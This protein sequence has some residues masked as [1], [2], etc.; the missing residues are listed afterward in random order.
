M[1]RQRSGSTF[2]RGKGKKITWWARLTFIDEVTGKRKDLQ[3]RAESKAHA[4]ELRDELVKEY[5][6]G[7]Q[8]ALESE[9]MT[10]ADLCDYYKA[11][12]ERLPGCAHWRRR[13]RF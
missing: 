4:E 6:N 2:K 12:G 7:G 9:R 10:F 5:D 11:Q 1:A 3:R 8:K 13:R